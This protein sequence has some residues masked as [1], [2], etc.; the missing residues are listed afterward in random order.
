[1]IHTTSQKT[2]PAATPSQILGSFIVAKLV[3]MPLVDEDVVEEEDN[4][5]LPLDEVVVDDDDEGAAVDVDDEDEEEDELLELS[6]ITPPVMTVPSVVWL[7]FWA[8]L[9][10][11][12]RVSGELALING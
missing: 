11:S 5:V 3:A 4:V 12:T 10:Y 6:T 2:N 7:A 1:M 8:A 9:R